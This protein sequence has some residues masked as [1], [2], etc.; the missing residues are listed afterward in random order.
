ML[1]INWKP[2]IF[3]M[4]IF[5][6]SLFDGLIDIRDAYKVETI[7]DAYM[8]VSGVPR[9]TSQHAS[10]IAHLSLDLK[11]AILTFKVPH[12]PTIHLKIRIGLHSGELFY[13]AFLRNKTKQ[14]KTVCMY[15]HTALFCLVLLWLFDLNCGFISII[16]PNTVEWLHWYFGNS[17]IFPVS[18][19]R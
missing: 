6:F 14:N 16:Y 12:D 11:A 19:N 4:P 8:V 17:I 7:G 13:K 1:Y 15:M 2:K 5:I 9:P 3:I 10:E 18:V